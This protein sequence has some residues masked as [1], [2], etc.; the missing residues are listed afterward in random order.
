VL[1]HDEPGK[2][3]VLQDC[4]KNLRL[5]QLSSARFSIK[6][7][8]PNPVSGS[9][10]INYSI[11]LPGATRIALYNASGVHVMDLVNENL[12]AGEYEL[13]LD[14]TAL[15]AGTYFYRVISG[16]YISDDQVLTVVR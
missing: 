7:I 13:T 6:P 15:P 3:E 5:V 1:F 11:G 2:L 14:V 12:A 10:V 16:P 9:A 8:A 4:A